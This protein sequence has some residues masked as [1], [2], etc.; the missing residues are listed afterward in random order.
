MMEVILRDDIKSLGKAGD[1]VR[2]KPGYARNFLL[3]Q[4]LAYEATEG[5]KKRIVAETKARN[6]RLAA[7]K[8]AALA[9]AEGLA[10]VA[11]TFTRKAGEEGKLFG[12]ITSQD[13]A[14]SLAAQGKT[15]DKRRIELPHPI[16]AVGEHT[17][18]VRL[19]P[20]VH[21]DVRVTVAAE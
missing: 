7:E 15:V 8:D 10:A 19:H 11:L 12:S 9:T 17:V 21:A 6:V 1:L 20:E 13:I 18:I 2:V 14:D 4:G 5:N 3:P 16:K